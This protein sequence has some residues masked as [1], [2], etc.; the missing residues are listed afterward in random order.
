MEGVSVGFGGKA[1]VDGV[2]LTVAAGHTLAVLGPSGCG[3]STL[4]RIVAGLQRPDRGRVVF[5]GVDLTETPTHRRGFALMFQDGQLFAHLD[6]A[7]NVGYALR[8][9]RLSRR[10][11]R[12]RVAD[13]LDLVG[14]AGLEDRRPGSLSG[15]QQQRVALAR[16]LA[17]EPR[18]LLL[19]EPLSALDATLREQ[20]ATQLRDVLRATGTTAIMVTHDQ[21]E[22]F[23][24][25]DDVALLRDGRVVQHGPALDVWRAPIDADAARFLGYRT[26]LPPEAGLSLGHPGRSTALR[27]NA[28]RVDSTG[29]IVA[30]VISSAAGPDGVRLEVQVEGLGALPAVTDDETAPPAG[31]RVRLRVQPSSV[32]ALPDIGRSVISRTD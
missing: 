27:R 29:P 28:L 3:K 6:V 21:E 23:A 32:A 1:A 30:T 5:D 14:L 15:G 9:R 8:R 19:D 2:D 4:L 12:A 7:Q 10:V 25:A 26:V 31:A 16:A 18:L 24:V 20:L 17:A 22:A 13:L 11:V